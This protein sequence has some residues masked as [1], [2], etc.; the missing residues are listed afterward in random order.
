[1]ITILNPAPV[2]VLS[3]DIYSYIDY[4]VINQTEGQLLTGDIS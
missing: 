2:Q 4:L 3:D 1:M